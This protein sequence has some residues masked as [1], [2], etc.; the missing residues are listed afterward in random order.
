MTRLTVASHPPCR[1]SR[2]RCDAVA[3]DESGLVQQ[4]AQALADAR[5]AAATPLA[6]LSHARAATPPAAGRPAR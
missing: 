5:I 6:Q 3:P 4:R 2:R 1:R